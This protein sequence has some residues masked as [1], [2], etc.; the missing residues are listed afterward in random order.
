MTMHLPALPAYYPDQAFTWAALVPQQRQGLESRFEALA[1]Q[2]A[3]IED[4][5]R[6]I[7]ESQAV[8][9]HA[10]IAAQGGAA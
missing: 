10:V 1:D 9:A 7:Q 8:L 2:L 4:A 5:V 6:A 3:R